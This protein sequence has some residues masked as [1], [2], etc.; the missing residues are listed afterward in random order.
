MFTNM[1][2]FRTV[3]L[4][5]I[6]LFGGCKEVLYSD[7][8]E[9]Q[10]NEMVAVLAA[11]GITTQ[12]ERDKNGIYSVLVDAENV[13]VAITLLR[14]EGLPREVFDNLGTVFAAD[15]IVGTPFEERARFIYAMNEELSR[16]ISGIDGVREA[17]VHIVLPR[18]ERFA[19]KLRAASA[20]VTVQV[21]EAFD[22]TGFV[23]R[24]RTMV[25][26]S[27]DTLEYDQVAVILFE[28]PEPLA[29]LAEPVSGGANASQ[30]ISYANFSTA[31]HPSSVLFQF[32][33][34]AAVIMLLALLAKEVT[35]RLGLRWGRR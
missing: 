11:A 17:R 29:V 8:I 18:E 7:L 19:D 25:S 15:G 30:T 32:A 10:A 22:S 33:I 21:E 28:R 5:S 27:V 13:A 3:A 31:G 26:H 23:S 4:I 14:K 12:R 35:R 1:R 2:Y 9:T 24:I 20:S 16:T 34:M 6:I